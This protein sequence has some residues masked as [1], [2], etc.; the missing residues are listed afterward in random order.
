[1]RRKDSMVMTMRCPSCKQYLVK[2]H[3]TEAW[4]CPRCKWNG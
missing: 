2:R 4:W 1:M 3:W